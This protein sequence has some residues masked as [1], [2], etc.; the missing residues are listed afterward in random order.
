[1]APKTPSKLR[2]LFY[3]DLHFSDAHASEAQSAIRCL[4]RWVGVLKPNLLVNLGDTFHQKDNVST[5]TLSLVAESFRELRDSLPSTTIHFGISGNHDIAVRDGSRSAADVLRLA[6]VSM[7]P[8]GSVLDA[9]GFKLGWLGY[10]EDAAKRQEAIEAIREADVLFAHAPFLGAKFNAKQSEE[11]STAL[12]PSRLGPSLLVVGHYHHPQVLRTKTCETIIVGSPA[13][14]T[15]G[16][17]VT[18]LEAEGGD[19]DSKGKVGDIVPRGFL[20]LELSRAEEGSMSWQA[21]R[22]RNENARVLMTVDSRGA[23]SRAA[24]VASVH[25]GQSISYRV[26]GSEA[27]EVA[28]VLTE[29]FKD[30]TNIRV[31]TRSSLKPSGLPTGPEAVD[32]QVGDVDYGKLL[33]RVL[34]ETTFDGVAVE[35]VK[36]VA[37]RILEQSHATA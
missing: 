11:G 26:T 32:F 8:S 29:V 14:Y 36:K 33:D 3:S 24:D 12:D 37:K 20:L 13:Y 6:W 27:D 17:S 5:L 23:A 10:V 7:A 30:R 28:G 16:D 2:I 34:Q 19:V 21:T 35:D 22:L 1:M 31:T 9:F 15:W 4:I 25:N 18:F